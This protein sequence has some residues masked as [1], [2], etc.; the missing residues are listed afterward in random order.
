[1]VQKPA[2]EPK[3]TKSDNLDLQELSSVLGAIEEK[4]GKK[5]NIEDMLKEV[6]SL[7]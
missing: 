2:E 3:V 4:M 1:M 6:D 7:V 5:E